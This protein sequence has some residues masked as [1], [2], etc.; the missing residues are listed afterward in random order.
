MINIIEADL[1]TLDVDAIVNAANESLLF[2]KYMWHPHFYLDGAVLH[3]GLFSILYLDA[4]L[5]K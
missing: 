1:T 3:G 2:P 4:V 5:Y